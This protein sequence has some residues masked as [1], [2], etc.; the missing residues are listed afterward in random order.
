[1]PSSHLKQKRKNWGLSV[2][3]C[4]RSRDILVTV[5]DTLGPHGLFNSL[6]HVILEVRCVFHSAAD[7]HKIV[8]NANCFPLVARNTSV[9]HAAGQLDKGLD[10]AER[11]SECEDFSQLAEA[12]GSGVTTLDAEGEH[13]AA[14]A[15]AVLLAGD[16]SVRVR[17]EAGV[18]DRNDMG[19]GLESSGYGC[20][21][22]RSLAGTE[23]QGLEATVSKPGVEG[24]GD[25]SDSIL[26]EGETLVDLVRV[27]R[28]NTHHDVRVTVDVLGHTVDD[29]VGAKVERILDVGR[30]EGVVNNDED[31][32][33]MSSGDDC[34]DVDK[35]QGW[36]AG[37][38]DPDQS[39]LVG[40]VLCDVDLNLR[41]EGD[42]DTMGLCDLGEVAVSSSVDI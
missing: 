29:D 23:V 24:G 40:D 37:R 26:E 25:G 8:K 19:R 5:G 2:D 10:A 20:S 6:K 34:T 30:K 21:I 1:M 12:L 18:V 36:V 4:V 17:V 16:V 39:G 31:P 33:A 15:L 38:L 35:A 41:G 3:V 27:E 32:V 28:G 9:G 13:T 14:H 11:L 42:A 22:T 7:S